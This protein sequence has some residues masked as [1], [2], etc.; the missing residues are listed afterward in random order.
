ML[1]FTTVM[2]IMVSLDSTVTVTKTYTLWDIPDAEIQIWCDP[3]IHG[4]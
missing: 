1:S 2:F 4:Y 3:L